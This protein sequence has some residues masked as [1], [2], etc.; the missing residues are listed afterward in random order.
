MG[1][2]TYWEWPPGL[3]WGSQALPPWRA[4]LPPLW[5]GLS[6]SLGSAVRTSCP[7]C[8]GPWQWWN[9]LWVSLPA[10]GIRFS[11]EWLC[12]PGYSYLKHQNQI[13]TYR[14]F[15]LKYWYK[16]NP[17]NIPYKTPCLLYTVRAVERHVV[18]H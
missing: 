4:G 12:R 13:L 16:D 18:V 8:W 3:F 14:K 7:S 6:R 17:W 10:G 9:A 11:Y 2:A 1:L 5:V 15:T